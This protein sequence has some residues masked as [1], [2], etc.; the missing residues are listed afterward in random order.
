MSGFEVLQLAFH[1]IN[2]GH[3]EAAIVGTANLALNSEISM[4][5]NDMGVLSP[6]GVTRS[7]DVDGKQC[8]QSFP[9]I[10]FDYFSQ[11]I[12]EK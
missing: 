8:Y 4:L 9:L 1:A 12:C 10:C 11:W 7:F 5:Y 3:V 2:N 6:D